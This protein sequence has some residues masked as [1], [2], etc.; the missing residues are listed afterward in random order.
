MMCKLVVLCVQVIGVGW[1]DVY[2][3]K[4]IGVWIFVE[5]YDFIGI[6]DQLVV[7]EIEVVLQ[8][9]E[10]GG[11]VWFDIIIDIVVILYS[12]GWYVISFVL[13]MVNIVVGILMFNCFVD[14]V[15]VL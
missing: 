10:D 11:W 2:W 8:F 15:N 9:F 6:E 12:G 3:I 7:V 4:V 14:C 1:V 5:G 13:G